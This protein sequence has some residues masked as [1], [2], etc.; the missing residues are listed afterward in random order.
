MGRRV[1]F[2]NSLLM[3]FLMS[4]DRELWKKKW[5]IINIIVIKIKKYPNFCYNFINL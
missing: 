1:C 5:V 2:G 4:F 3:R